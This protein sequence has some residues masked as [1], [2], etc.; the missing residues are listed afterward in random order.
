M[1]DSGVVVVVLGKFGGGTTVVTGGGTLVMAE[2]DGGGL[3]AVLRGG[4]GGEE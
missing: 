1:T 3:G 2:L 4:D